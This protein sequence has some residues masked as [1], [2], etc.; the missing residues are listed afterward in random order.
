MNGESKRQR[1]R[2]LASRRTNDVLER[3][4][5]LGNLSNRSFYD[6]EDEDVMIMFTAIEEQLRAVKAK[7]ISVRRRKF[8]L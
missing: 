6:Y 7:F 4:R 3:L 2:R 8:K 1:F 5:I